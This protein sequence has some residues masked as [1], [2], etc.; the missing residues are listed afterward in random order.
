MF[1]QC[2]LAGLLTVASW[3]T[4]AAAPMVKTQAPGFYRVM[5]GDF[6]VT[7]LS[8]GTVMLP[9]NKLLHTKSTDVD[10]ILAMA[11]LSS[12]LETS[13]NA[14]LVNTGEKLILIDT[15][16]GGLFGPTLGGLP[17]SL[18]AAGY[19]PEQ[20]DEVYI[21]HLHGDHIGGLMAG[22]QRAFPNAILRAD[23]HDLDYWLSQANMD[24]APEEV[25]LFFKGAMA[26]ANPYLQAGKL[27]PFK[28]DT[29]LIPG[30]KAVASHGHTAGHTHFLVESRGQKLAVWGDLLHVA[31]VQFAQPRI[32]IQFDSNSKAAEKERQKA[33]AAAA[34]EGYL[35]G[36]AHVSF[37]G[38]GHLR[39]AGKGYEWQPVNYT[40]PAR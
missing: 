4:Y 2:L 3:N 11:R 1:A 12:P 17:E 13:V 10:R 35:V 40:V 34:R 19:E 6:E 31:A 9:V 29:D 28:G 16:A 5:L 15:G 21:T 38:L 32:T 22:D 33:F 27:L 18:R 7:A 14:Y 37:P 23:Q 20:I 39:K 30:I 26:M 25:K 8:D 24:A 36:A